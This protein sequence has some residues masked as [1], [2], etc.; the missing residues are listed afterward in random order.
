M[1]N[2]GLPAKLKK[3]CTPFAD[4]SEQAHSITLDGVVEV[5]HLGCAL[6]AFGYTMCRPEAPIAQL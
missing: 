4:H 1:F 5:Q 2:I 3:N 6:A